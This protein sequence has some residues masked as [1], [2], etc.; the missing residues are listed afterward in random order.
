MDSFEKHK[1]LA[2]KYVQHTYK[3]R[4]DAEVLARNHKFVRDE[5]ADASSSSW[6]VRM[7]LKYYQRL[8]KEYCIC[9]LSRHKEGAI[10]LRWRTEREVLSGKGQF[11]CGA[12]RCD[13]REG[14]HSYE[15][16]FAYEESGATRNELIK[17]RLCG[18]CAEKLYY[19]K[20][21]ELRKER[22]R[23]RK[24]REREAAAAAGG[25][26]T[27]GASPVALTGHALVQEALASSA[28]AEAAAAAVTAAVTAAD[29]KGKGKRK[30]DPDGSSSS[31][32][33]K[34]AAV[35]AD[36][37][38]SSAAVDST[39]GIVEADAGEL[40]SRP[41]EVA[42]TAGDDMDEYLNGLFM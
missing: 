31:R 22:H 20:L 18:P 3:G 40:W 9:D 14:L 36:D 29:H 21:K 25:D 41:V 1:V 2:K 34:K 27:A 15:V 30:G 17:C 39:S 13:T 6:E 24:R 8:S 37:D 32:H 26:S 16:N 35:A 38:S 23:A 4:T 42:R 28:Q 33:A 5:A 19:R 10:G 12:V 11:E 7:A